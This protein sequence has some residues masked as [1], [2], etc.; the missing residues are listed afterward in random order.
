MADQTAKKVQM[1]ITNCKAK[2]IGISPSLAIKRIAL[3]LAQIRG[4]KSVEIK[5]AL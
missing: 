4:P 3:R 1:A 5:R 2:L